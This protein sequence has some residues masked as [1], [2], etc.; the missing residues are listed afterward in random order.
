MHKDLQLIFNE[1]L[2]VSDVDFGCAEGHRTISRQQELYAQGRTKPGRKVTRI[3]GVNQM[4]KHNYD[5]SLAGD[6]YA[7]LNGK[8]NWSERLLI[9]IGGVMTATA[10]RL[11]AEG[12][13]THALRWGGNWDR[14]GEIVTDQEFDDLPH[15]ELVKI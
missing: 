6:I 13:I 14:D 11:L 8:A 2:K 9:Y 7:W 5:P 15:F 1:A 10:A 3:D 12:R 4:S